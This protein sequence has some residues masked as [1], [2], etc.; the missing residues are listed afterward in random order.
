MRLC[1]GTFATILNLCKKNNVSQ[2]PF[3]AKIVW[4]VD[5][6]NSCIGYEDKADIIKDPECISGEKTKVSRLLSC[7]REF[8]Y[9]SVK[10]ESKYVIE[11]LERAIS[12]DLDEDKKSKLVFALLDIIRRDK[13]ID[14]EKK[15]TFKAYLGVYKQELLKKDKFILFDFLGRILLYTVNG[16][17]D[18]S[19]GKSC[20]KSITNDSIE[21]FA[22][23]YENEYQ[24][25]AV[26]QTL[27]LKFVQ[28]F[29]VFQQKIQEYQI[30]TFIVDIDPTT[31]LQDKYVEDYENFIDSL[32]NNME[33]FSS[34]QLGTTCEK[35]EKFCL[36]LG[37]YHFYLGT[38][39][40]SPVYYYDAPNIS[41]YKAISNYF[42]PIHRDENMSWYQDFIA[43]VMCFRE[44]LAAILNEIINHM[45]FAPEPLPVA[46]PG[47]VLET[48][49]EFA[50]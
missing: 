38:H 31:F 16:N 9:N 50:K 40:M 32:R 49:Q 11:R 5:N 21:H 14:S 43:K 17:I 45:L 47:Q 20:V 6:H 44:Q 7:T 30:D 35:I 48:A 3:I 15:E 41:D 28:I 12:A 46:E 19:V 8:Q 39:M 25:D 26:T 22:S 2:T 23:L 33:P 4:S 18:N 42:V 36:L 10:R 34:Y 13:C 37:E 24:W 1:F 27:T 29:D